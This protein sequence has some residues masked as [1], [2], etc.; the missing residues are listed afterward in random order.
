VVLNT[1]YIGVPS[2][3]LLDVNTG[4]VNVTLGGKNPMKVKTVSTS[5]S[6][7][8]AFGKAGNKLSYRLGGW[9]SLGSA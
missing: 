2:D 4:K 6:Y 5:H 9:N 3:I 8:A 1:S 7:T